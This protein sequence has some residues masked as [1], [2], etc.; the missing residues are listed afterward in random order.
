MDIQEWMNTVVV[1]SGIGEHPSPR[2]SDFANSAPLRP[3][4]KK[5]T[6]NSTYRC[7]G[8]FIPLDASRADKLHEVKAA[9]PVK[10]QDFIRSTDKDQ[11]TGRNV[12][13]KDVNSDS[14]ADYKRKPR[15]KTRPE[16]YDLKTL[17]N[18]RSKT[19]TRSKQAVKKT[20]KKDGCK[21]KFKE[22]NR[23]VPLGNAHLR[24]T[25]LCPSRPRL[26]VC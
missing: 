14:S 3:K 4:Q 25:G 13:T 9:V 24:S 8:R 15:R 6:T 17:N 10:D 2:E 12:F 1:Q 18:C 26:S 21:K 11:S 16:R 20:R 23:A 19:I 22:N 5:Y 7:K